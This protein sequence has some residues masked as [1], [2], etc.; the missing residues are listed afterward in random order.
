M[1]S[2]QASLDT[3]RNAQSQQSGQDLSTRLASLNHAS[4]SPE[5]KEKKLREA[6]EGFESIFIQKMWQEMRKTVNQS[7]FLHGREEQ[8]WQDMYDQELAKKMTSAGGIG[9]ANMMYEQLSSHLTS[10]SRATARA[11]D[12]GR[13]F[14]PSQAP[15]L[16]NTASANASI[17]LHDEPASS[18]KTTSTSFYEP[19]A[20]ANEG[21]A[22]SSEESGS[23]TAQASPVVSPSSAAN[24]LPQT[25]RSSAQA[26]QET[27]DPEIARALAMMRDSVQ[28]TP[29]DT[30]APLA[31]VNYSVPGARQQPVASGMDLAK[32]ARRQAGDQLGSR[33]V[34]E[35]LLPQTPAARKATEEALNRQEMRHQRQQ[36]L[37]YAFPA[38]QAEAQNQ[39]QLE[40]PGVFAPMTQSTAQAPRR[41]NDAQAAARPER[42]HRQRS[43]SPH[44]AQPQAEIKTL[45]IASPQAHQAYQQQAQAATFAAPQPSPAE[46]VKQSIP[47]LTAQDLHI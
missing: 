11:Q 27:V 16:G 18:A 8:F 40:Q 43:V 12:N 23:V 15:L 36:P 13:A 7:S 19:P 21:K 32:A 30:H 10:A 6:C 42:S 1:Q 26:S 2:I 17:P 31:S 9:L 44:A 29:Q 25:P 41:V 37:P 34:R 20:P 46:P 24:P 5:A 28:A 35:P 39:E 45:N 33:G 4:L 38:G 14:V 3:A 47:P 22:Q